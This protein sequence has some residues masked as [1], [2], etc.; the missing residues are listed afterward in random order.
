MDVGTFNGRHGA[1]A[2]GFRGL[3][4]VYWNMR[5]PA[6]AEEAVR[7]SEAV[8]AEGGALVAETGQHTGRSP[9]DK[10]I[11]RDALT[12]D[13]VWWDNN[14]AITPEQFETLYQDCLA[15]AKGRELFSQDLYGGTDPDYRI[16]VRVFTEYAW[17][18]LFIRNLLVRPDWSELADFVPDLT[19]LDLPSFKADPA[20]HGCRSET[21]IACDLTRRIVLIGGTSYAGEMKKSVFT[22]L[23]FMLPP[24][25]VMPMHCS[26]NA[27]ADGDVAV[28]FGLSGTGKTTLSADPGRTLIGDDEH[29][30]GPK[31]V[32][33]FEGGCYAKAIRLSREAEPEIF[34][35][36]ERFGTVMENV[37][38]DPETRQP[39]FDD[40]SRTENTRIAYPLPFIPNASATGRAGQPTNIVM[41]TCDAFGVLPPIARLTPAQAMYH[42]LS[43]YTAKVAGTEKGVTDPQATFSTCFGAPFM[44]RHPSVY[45]NLLRDLIARHGV[46]CW[47]VNT[48]WTGGK[49]GTG[50]RMPIRVTRRLLSAALDGSLSRADYRTDPYFGFA[51]PTSVPGV[52]PHILHPSKTWASKAE[53]AETARRLVGMFRKNFEAFERHVDSEVLAAAPALQLAAE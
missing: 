18:S 40:G 33:N 51:V 35:T 44:P 4:R 46:D 45:G 3:K 37:V 52:E 14:G 23:N 22:V 49:F 36:T 34:A 42:F 17:H 25:A 16:G 11:V 2:F 29:G 19:I 6:L 15:H 53:F 1:Q 9:K 10:F 26:A 27:G 30:W 43:G 7:R 21:V 8:L 20:R 32:F 41:L 13:T 48:G 50:R 47:L 24:K 31:G 39:D 12:A 38:L 28:F 5:A